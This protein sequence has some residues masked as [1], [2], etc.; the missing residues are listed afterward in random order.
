MLSG[1]SHNEIA[2]TWNELERLVITK[3]QCSADMVRL[4]PSI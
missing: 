1:K 3:C 4:V 2:M